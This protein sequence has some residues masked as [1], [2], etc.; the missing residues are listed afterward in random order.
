MNTS[1]K[2]SV[3]VAL[4]LL[5][6]TVSAQNFIHAGTTELGGDVSFSSQSSPGSSGT[7]TTFSFNPYVGFM[8][9]SGFELGLMPGITSISSGS[10]SATELNLF[11]APSYNV[12]TGSTVYPYFE[13]LIGYNSISYKSGFSFSGS[14]NQTVDGLGI[15][16]DA[17]LKVNLKGNSLLLFKIQYLYQSYKEDATTT[18]V[19]GTTY[20]TPSSETILNTVAFGMGFRVFLEKKEKQK[21]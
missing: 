1:K 15:G 19:F 20:T 8:S 6:L 17:G 21:K 11:L 16:L 14:G 18:N 9:S 3:V 4:W 13:F 10:E 5:S 2:L 7:I 12:S